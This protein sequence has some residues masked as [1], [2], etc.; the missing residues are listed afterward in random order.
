MAA[1]L[2]LSFFFL[3]INDL[4]NDLTTARGTKIFTADTNTNIIGQNISLIFN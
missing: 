1:S 3:Y 4:A 2:K